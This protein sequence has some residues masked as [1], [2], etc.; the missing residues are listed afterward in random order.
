MH[1]FSE[2]TASQSPLRYWNARLAGYYLSTPFFS[3]STA[4]LA[5]NYD[6]TSDELFNL[7]AWD[8][9]QDLEGFKEDS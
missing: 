5:L 1:P 9:G 7:S 6:F 8:L 4:I 2:L 3:V